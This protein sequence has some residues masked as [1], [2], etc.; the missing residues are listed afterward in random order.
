MK[1]RTVLRLLFGAVVILMLSSCLSTE[2]SID[3]SDEQDIRLDLVYTIPRAVWELGVFDSTSPERAIPIS[4]R[5]ARETAALYPDVTLVDHTLRQDGE[6]V[7]V[8]IE[9]SVGSAESLAD[10]WG[11]AGESRLEFDPDS[12]V[13][14]IP[15][16]GAQGPVDREQR[17]LIDEV[18]RDQEFSLTVRAPARVDTTGPELP[19][20]AWDQDTVDNTATWTAPMGPLVLYDRSAFVEVRWEVP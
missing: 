17:E 18:F 9:Y 14:R 20:A 11:W 6:I 1:H 3:V 7:A 8:S 13:L 2:V 5:D 19:D 15:V 4:E 16:H 12:G 10:L